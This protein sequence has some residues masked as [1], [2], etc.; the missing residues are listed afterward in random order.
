M[1]F[2]GAAFTVKYGNATT[3][4]TAHST[5]SKSLYEDLIQKIESKWTR[6]QDIDYELLAGNMIISGIESLME[7]PGPGGLVLKVISF[8][9]LLLTCGALVLVLQSSLL[10]LTANPLQV[11]VLC[12]G[13]SDF[14]MNEAAAYLD[15][16]PDIPMVWSSWTL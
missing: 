14:T 2:T 3:T 16:S 11:N 13:F 5:S 4:F 12:K 1:R 15:V 10:P 7:S 6:L 8:W 9:I